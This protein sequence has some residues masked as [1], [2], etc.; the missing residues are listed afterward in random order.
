MHGSPLFAGDMSG[1]ELIDNF[2]HP[3]GDG[4]PGAP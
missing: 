1:Y 2:C 4:A 3:E